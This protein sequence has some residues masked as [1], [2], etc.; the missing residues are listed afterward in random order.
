MKDRIRDRGECCPS[1][2]GLLHI[3]TK[4]STVVGASFP[5]KPSTILPSGL[6]DES[7]SNEGYSDILYI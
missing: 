4:F 3:L 5:Y 6:V 7:Y 1:T 2:S